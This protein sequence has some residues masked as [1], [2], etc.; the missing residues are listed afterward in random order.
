MLL[1]KQTQDGAG[2]I[3]FLA[4]EA[5]IQSAA[6]KMYKQWNLDRQQIKECHI[7]MSED[8]ALKVVLNKIIGAARFKLLEG[9]KLVR[10]ECP[11]Q[12]NKERDS[13]DH[14]QACYSIPE[15]GQVRGPGIS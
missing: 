10:A 2:A 8:R 13:W 6:E 12:G 15:I 9:A 1:R 3:Q 4:E 11:K 5:G 7:L 14:F